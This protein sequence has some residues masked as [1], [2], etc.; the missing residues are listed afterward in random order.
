[1]TEFKEIR[2]EWK[3][4]KKEEENQ[5]KADEERARSVAVPTDGQGPPDNGPAP[6]Y[7]QAVAVATVSG[8]TV[9]GLTAYRL[10]TGCPGPW[11]VSSSSRR[12]A[13]T[14][15][16]RQQSYL[17]LGLPGFAIWRSKPDV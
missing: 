7:Q 8:G 5:R 1:M 9:S 11:P 4:R 2:K 13:T 6:G 10:P 16:V 14:A 12:C 15:R 3:A 17:V